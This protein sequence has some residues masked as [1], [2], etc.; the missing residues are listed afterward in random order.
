MLRFLLRIKQLWVYKGVVLPINIL[1]FLQDLS[2]ILM[3]LYH[4]GNKD[5]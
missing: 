3:Q 4:D 2:I 5:E 1:H